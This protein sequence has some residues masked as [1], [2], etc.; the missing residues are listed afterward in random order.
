MAN[1]KFVSKK[2][3]LHNRCEMCGNPIIFQRVM[4]KFGKEDP[5]SLKTLEGREYQFDSFECM[6]SYDFSQNNDN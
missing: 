6:Q 2:V 5:N 3:V 1:T 4:V